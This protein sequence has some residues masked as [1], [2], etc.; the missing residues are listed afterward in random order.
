MTRT[1]LS[2]WAAACALQMLMMLLPA[3]PARAQDLEEPRARQGYWIAVGFSGVG[4]SLVEKGD[5]IGMYPG[6]GF[7]VRLGQLLT[8][9][10]GLGMV[11]DYAGMKKAEDAGALGGL[12]LECNLGLWRNLAVHTGVGF[13]FVYVTD[14][15]TEERELRGGAGANLLAGV[16][17]DFFPWRKRLSGGWAVT[18]TL[19]FRAMPDGNIH[20]Y[21]VFLGVQVIRWSGLARNM[22]ILPEE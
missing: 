6:S 21:T 18:P 5:Y 17:Y 10:I 16:S 7:T 11:V 14:A 20:S 2:A 13:G 22:L 1:R 15:A 8:R 3:R 19:N 4:A 9:R 12:S